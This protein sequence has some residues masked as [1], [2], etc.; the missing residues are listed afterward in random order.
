MVRVYGK[1]RATFRINPPILKCC[2]Y[3]KQ[4]LI[5]DIIVLLRGYYFPRVVG[6]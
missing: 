4:F 6:N 3:Y 2:Y 1:F 5:V